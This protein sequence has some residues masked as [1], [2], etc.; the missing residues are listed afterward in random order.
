MSRVRFAELCDVNACGKRSEE[1]TSWP[2]CRE[3]NLDVCPEHM[4]E[5]SLWDGDD[6]IIETCICVR[7]TQH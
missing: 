1:Y 2:V 3:C 6:E 5:G 4:A 7:C